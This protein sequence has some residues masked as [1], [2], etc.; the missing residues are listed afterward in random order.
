MKRLIIL[1]TIILLIVNA[2]FGLIITAYQPTNVYLNT[3]VILFSGITL[4]AISF[5]HMKD[6]FKISL[7]SLFAIVSGIEYILGFFAPA[8]W[9]NN[10]FAILVIVVL[11]IEIIFVLLTNYVTNKNNRV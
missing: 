9:D 3:A 7:T 1:T 5:T 11:A 10:W 6:A 4:L 2:L 8:E